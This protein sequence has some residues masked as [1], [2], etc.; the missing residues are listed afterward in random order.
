LAGYK[1]LYPAKTCFLNAVLATYKI[2]YAAKTYPKANTAAIKAPQ[3]YAVKV[4]DA[5]MFN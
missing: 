4:C 1:K 2:V 5:T 3:W